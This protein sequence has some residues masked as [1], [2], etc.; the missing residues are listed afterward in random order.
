MHSIAPETRRHCL[1]YLSQICGRRALLPKSLA[2]PLC[3]NQGDPPLYRGGFGDVYKGKYRGM[4][5]AA[6]VLRVYSTS[7]F[8][9]IAKVGHPWLVVY[10]NEPTIFCAAVLQRSCDMEI[11]SSSK[12]DAAVGRNNDREEFC[13]GIGVDD[14]W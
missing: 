1:Q 8:E 2:I 5:V 13:D 6:K 3:Y 11:P 9:K 14:E 10:D 7:D 12:R 4:N